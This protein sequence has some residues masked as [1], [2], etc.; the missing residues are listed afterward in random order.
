MSFQ[1]ITYLWL[2]LL[3]SNTLPSPVDVHIIIQEF[4]SCKPTRVST[5]YSSFTSTTFNLL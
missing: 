2:E 3:C 1:L 5:R 4:Q